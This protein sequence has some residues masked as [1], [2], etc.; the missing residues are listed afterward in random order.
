MGDQI[1]PDALSLIVRLMDENMK[2]VQQ[3]HLDNQSWQAQTTEVL[4]KIVEEQKKT[5][6]NVIR[7]EGRLD[8]IEKDLKQLFSRVARKAGGITQKD[9]TLW[10]AI[11]VGVFMV[12]TMVLGY[13]K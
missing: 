5:N 7:H 1:G 8:R 12:M 13:H 9:V 2:G 6:G 11:I 10:A 3:R 4:H